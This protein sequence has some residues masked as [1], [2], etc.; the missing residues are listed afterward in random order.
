MQHIVFR[1][2]SSYEIGTGHVM[3]CLTL[4]KEIRKQVEAEI[5]FFSRNSQGNINS[6]IESEGFHLVEMEAPGE[7]KNGELKHCAWLGKTPE[8][9]AEEFLNLVDNL[10]LPKVDCLVIDHYGIDKKWQSLVSNVA[11]KTLVID[12]L[13]DRF[14]QCDFLLDQT[15]NSKDEKY[16]KLVPLGC[17]LL[18]GTKYALLREEFRETVITGAMVDQKRQNKVLVMFGGTDP[19][20]LTL[21]S[22]HILVK[23]KDV[24]EINV[25][26]GPSAMHAVEV[27]Q[28][29][30]GRANITLHISPSNIA[31]LMSASDL[32]VG[33]AGTTSWERCASGLPAV[34]VIQADNQRQIAKELEAEG[35][36][37]YLEEDE[38][39]LNLN[40]HIDQ[41]LSADN[42]KDKLKDKCIEICDAMGSNRV[43]CEL[44]LSN[45]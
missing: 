23:R 4:A 2:D 8:A 26:L 15:F 28:F 27:K 9:D 41:W 18:L 25:I 20:N 12:D 39:E 1:V 7:V 24:T 22:L 13:G 45:K 42:L 32:A 43:I 30:E 29:C 35:V 33:A 44:F 3:R 6:L 17:K 19:T 11:Y 38:I 14:H 31:E 34:V 5:Y 40:T 21:K 36:I 10:E 16:N 37:T